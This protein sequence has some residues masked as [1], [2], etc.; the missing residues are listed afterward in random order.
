M[1]IP[2]L[3]YVNP[4]YIYVVIMMQ[5][6]WMGFS[7]A[8]WVFALIHI[9]PTDNFKLIS[10]LGLRAASTALKK[11]RER[12]IEGKSRMDSLSYWNICPSISVRA[13]NPSVPLRKKNKRMDHIEMQITTTSAT[14]PPLVSDLLL[15]S[16]NLLSDW[17]VS[18]SLTDF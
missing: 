2:D 4:W 11:E 13:E 9:W 12:Q 8:L 3:F 15:F 17:I 10:K 16:Q 14:E 5:I 6:Y 18:A 1:T 7:A